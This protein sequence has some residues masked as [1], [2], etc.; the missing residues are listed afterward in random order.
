[1]YYSEYYISGKFAILLHEKYEISKHR[2]SVL[3]NFVHPWIMCVCAC[4]CMLSCVHLFCDPMDYSNPPHPTRL[5]CPWNFPDKNTGVG[6]LT[7]LQGIFSTQGSNLGLTLVP[8]LAS[9]FF[10]TG[11]PGKPMSIEVTT[12]AQRESHHW[13][14]CWR[15][16]YQNPSLHCSWGSWGMNAR[17][18]CLSLLQ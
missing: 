5:L 16:L 6:C 13:A 7:L 18:V 12:F 8:A 4:M 9:I 1:M 14:R 10:T 17:V 3:K 15:C 11:L 2:E